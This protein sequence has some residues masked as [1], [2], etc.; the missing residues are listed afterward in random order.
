MLL[1]EFHGA[2]VCICHCHWLG[3]FIVNE[4]YLYLAVYKTQRSERQLSALN[5]YKLRLPVL[6]VC[7]YEELWSIAKQALSI[8][9]VVLRDAIAIE[10][11]K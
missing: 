10:M 7:A 1:E 5:L 3:L 2:I 8:I 11:V 6:N 9:K 4:L